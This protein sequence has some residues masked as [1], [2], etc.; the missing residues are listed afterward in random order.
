MKK[1]K[2]NSI[3]RSL[4]AGT[5]ALIL[6]FSPLLSLETHAFW[7]E[8]VQEEFHF[9]RLEIHESI[10]GMLLG[11]LKRQAFQMLNDQVDTLIGGGSGGEVAFITD[12]EDY[13]IHQAENRTQIYMN[14]YL[15]QITSGRGSRSGYSSEGFVEGFTGVFTN[16][17]DRYCSLILSNT[18]RSLRLLLSKLL[19]RGSRYSTRMTYE[20]CPDEMFIS[21]SFKDL[22]RYISGINNP[23]AFEINVQN[24]YNKKL[25]SEK[26][27]QL[28]KAM[29]YGGFKGTTGED[30]S[31]TY[32]GSLTKENTANA[33]NVGNLMVATA[34]SIQEAT[35]AA[36]N[37]II[38]RAQQGFSGTL[39]SSQKDASVQSRIDTSIDSAVE[40]SG[41]EAI[42]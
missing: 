1:Q 20:R 9:V 19:P 35:A 17:L 8:F 28:A 38:S 16:C 14:D 5:L 39:R 11:N 34:Q 27:V 12:W 29:A 24:E 13:L 36:V 25:E 40:S 10:K 22:N 15:T 2:I 31:V 4:I 18:R 42:Y 26:E 23:W 6:M 32:P 33:Q 30:G 7:G 3:K 21:D 41:P 37:I